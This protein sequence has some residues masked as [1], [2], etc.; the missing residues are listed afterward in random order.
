MTVR[1]SI[2]S[3]VLQVRLEAADTMNKPEG[4]LQ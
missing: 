2:A 3:R 4:Y 1:V